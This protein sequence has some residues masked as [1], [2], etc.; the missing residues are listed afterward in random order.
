M[1]N[2]LK[3]RFNEYTR[4]SFAPAFFF[5]SKEQKNAL[6]VVYKFARM[7]DDAVDQD[8]SEDEKR[9]K[10]KELREKI[11]GVYSGDSL[12]DDFFGSMRDVVKRYGIPEYC[13]NELLNGMEMD[14]GYVDIKTSDELQIYMFRVASVVGVMVLLISDYDGSDMDEIAKY[15]GYA[16]Q[17]TNILRDIDEDISYGRV[18]IPLEH[19]LKFLGTDKIDTN[20]KKFK[21]LFEFEKGIAKSYYKKANELFKKNKS[22]KLFISAVM[23]NIYYEIFCSLSFD[24]ISKNHK[25][26][27]YKKAKAILKSFSETYF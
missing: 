22:R 19:R 21:E 6:S 17:L 24:K 7:S 14:L 2:F 15:T 3:D 9:L 5:L 4:S 25:I 1:I 27:N 18:Y 8:A 16:L 26:S 13:F 12:N 23:K 11:K 10:L 20:N